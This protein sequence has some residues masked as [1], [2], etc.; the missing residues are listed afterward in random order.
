MAAV[1][2]VKSIRWTWIAAVA[3]GVWIGIYVPSCGQ[4]NAPER[5]YAAALE[6]AR[7]T[8]HSTRD[9]FAKLVLLQHDV[10]ADSWI[11]DGKRGQVEFDKLSTWANAR[12]TV[13]ALAALN[14]YDVEGWTIPDREGKLR[15]IVLVN[16]DLSPT[17]RLY[18]LFHELAHTLTP[19]DAITTTPQNET[20]AE[21]VAVQACDRLGIDAWQQTALYLHMHASLLDQYAVATVAGAKVDDV[22]TELVHVIGA[23]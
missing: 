7:P 10:A 21:L 17:D 6:P 23:K 14:A 4:D 3:L 5:L 20:F 9:A 11:I 18:T 13:V 12:G 2:Q 1:A 8:V 22:V 19:T 15:F 16:S